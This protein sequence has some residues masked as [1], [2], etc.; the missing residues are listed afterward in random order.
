MRHQVRP[1]L[2]AFGLIMLYVIVGNVL[3]VYMPTFAVHELRLP[4]SGALFAT[5][6]G[7]MHND[8]MYTACGRGVRSQF[9]R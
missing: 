9:G 3:F 2:V 4:S 7:N 1:L 6:V 5:I 8:R